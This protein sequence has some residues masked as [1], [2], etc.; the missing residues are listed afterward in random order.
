MEALTLAIGRYLDMNAFGL[1]RLAMLLEIARSL[2]ACYQSTEYP[3]T[4]TSDNRRSVVWLADDERVDVLKYLS[5]KL[6]VLKRD[7]FMRSPLFC[8]RGSLP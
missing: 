5:R 3:T 2:E 8:P 4:R 6:G 1:C 7:S